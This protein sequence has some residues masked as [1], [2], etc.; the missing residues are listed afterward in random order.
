MGTL[1]L[2]EFGEFLNLRAHWTQNFIL[3][4]SVLR[5]GVMEETITDMHLFAIADRY[6][7][8]IITKKFNRREE[9]ARSGA[10]WLWIVG[11]PGNWLPILIQAK[12]INPQT[13]N[14]YHFDYKNGGQRK[15]LLNYARQNHCLPLYCIYSC[16]PASFS[17]PKWPSDVVHTNEDWACAFISPKSIRDLSR[18]GIRDQHTILKHCIPWAEP[19]CLTHEADPPCGETIATT[20]L[21]IRD[22]I[23]TA[24]R[25][26]LPRP[27]TQSA[28]NPLRTRVHWEH[29]D[30]TRAIWR[31][32]PQSI[33]RW[34]KAESQEGLDVPIPGISIISAVPI[35]GIEELK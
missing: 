26:Y 33:C 29:L 24:T 18:N 12:V 9:G 15:L 16:I 13:K 31:K 19:F 32:I 10:D 7:D 30:T 3:R 23:S 1:N 25:R 28:E 2:H 27:K 22:H 20:F 14:C 8:N 35:H 21:S 17:P 34:V 6:G 5:L 4:S 11:A